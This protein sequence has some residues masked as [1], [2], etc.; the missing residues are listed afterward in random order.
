MRV[1]VEDAAKRL[2]VRPQFIRLGLQQERLP[3][4]TAVKTSS[5]WTYY[6]SE[7]ALN[8]YIEEGNLRSTQNTNQGE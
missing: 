3:F 7:E 2:G 5:V 4:G 6:I 1:K 8:K